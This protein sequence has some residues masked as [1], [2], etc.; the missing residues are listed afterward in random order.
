MLGLYKFMLALDDE[1]R[2]TRYFQA[3]TEEARQEG[4]REG[5]Q[6]AIWKQPITK[7][8]KFGLSVEQIAA[9]LNLSIEQVRQIAARSPNK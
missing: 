2:K 8:L 4:I 5:I 6:E 9:A 7:L 1:L 3:V